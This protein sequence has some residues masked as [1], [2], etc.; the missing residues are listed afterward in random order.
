[1]RIVLLGPPGGGKGTQAAKLVEKYGIPHISTGDLLRGAVAAGTEL[2]KKAKSVMDSGNLVS[3]DLVLGILEDRLAEDDAKVGFIL[4][5]FPRNL[6]QADMLEKVLDR[7]EQPL[8]QAVQVEVPNDLL[9][10]RILSRGQGR[11]DDT[12]EVVRN[13]LDIYEEQ[14]APVAGYYAEKEKLTQI[15][16]VGEIDEVFERICTALDSLN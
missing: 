8:D 6:V 12:E 5:G 9:I 15:Y 10:E 7:I 13:R 2:G 14:T 11:A 3:D 1:M 16:G 4:D